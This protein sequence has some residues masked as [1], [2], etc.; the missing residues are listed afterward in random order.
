MVGE[1]VQQGT[2]IN[3]FFCGCMH[4]ILCRLLLGSSLCL[5]VEDSGA[6]FCWPVGL[7]P[8]YFRLAVGS[9]CHCFVWS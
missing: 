5:F 1:A 3:V 2:T 6:C 4:E 8:C 9:V 7:S